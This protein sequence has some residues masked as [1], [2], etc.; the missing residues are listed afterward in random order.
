MHLDY[1]VIVVG[2]GP[3]G[4]TAARFCASA[5]LKTLL[6]EK[7]QLPRYKPCGGC[8]SVKGV[9][10]LGFD[11]SPVIENSVYGAR[12]TYCFK[13]P[14]SIE[15]EEPIAF[16]VRRDRF[17]QLLILKA[18]ENGA[19]KLE[20]EKVTRAEEKGNGI[21]VELAKGERIRCEYLIGADGARSVVAKS[22]FAFRIR[23]AGDGIGLECEIPFESTIDFP[24]EDLHMMHFDFGR[25]PNGYGWVF[26]KGKWLSIGVG[27]IFGRRV[28]K[29]PRQHFNDM[30]KCLDFIQG[31]RIG[32]A[33][34]HPIPSFY[35]GEQK[36]SLGKV[37]LVGDAA[38]LVDPLTGE[39]IY[40]ALRS[41]MLAAE[42]ILQSKKNGGDASAHY[43]RTVKELLFE[44]LRSAHNVSQFIYRFTQVAY[45]TL[46]H[47]PELGNFYIQVLEGKETY[48]GF[49]TRV[50]DRAR[51][52]LKGS[53]SGKLKRVLAKP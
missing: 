26:P 48:H 32:K 2:G 3:A 33:L 35:S 40:Y 17:D 27:G 31:S 50:K 6:I 46:K 36:V 51:D 7:E 42:A 13:S 8:L 41:G 30:I 16:M 12:F 5:G 47:Y 37:F 1:D 45:R 25:V 19:E 39:G 15:S 38:H 14:F 23:G 21:D 18:L 43:Q 24:K 53:L 22:F 20:G 10:L 44:D 11:L 52:L 49:V 28:G 34:A 4:S 29:T 9:R